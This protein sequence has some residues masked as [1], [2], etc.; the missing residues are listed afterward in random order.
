[1]AKS[2]VTM[3][4]RERE[5]LSSNETATLFQATQETIAR[6][7]KADYDVPREIPH[8]L[9]VLLMQINER[10]RGR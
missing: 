9:L 6:S 5:V 7:L 10:K 3:S 4:S 8:Q 2:G 1:M